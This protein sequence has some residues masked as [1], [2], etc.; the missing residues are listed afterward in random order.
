MDKKY[1]R[2][3]PESYIDSIKIE[4]SNSLTWFLY[5]I[6]YQFIRKKHKLDEE[7]V[8]DFWIQYCKDYGIDYP[9]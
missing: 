5:N 9:K 8:K 6:V 4:V 1:W 7:R 3:K 2:C